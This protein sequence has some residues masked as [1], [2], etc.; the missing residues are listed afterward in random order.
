RRTGYLLLVTESDVGQCCCMSQDT[1]APVRK[2]RWGVLGWARIARENVIPAIQ[3]SSN[4][5]FHAI[6][7]RDPARLVECRARFNVAR[8]YP[9]YDELLHDESVEAVYIPLPN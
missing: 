2:I 8:A 6:A 9:S 5:E 1:T 7:S 3:R 4:S